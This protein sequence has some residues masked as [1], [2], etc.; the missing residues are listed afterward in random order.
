MGRDCLDEAISA[1]GLSVQRLSRGWR[2]DVGGW[3]DVVVSEEK[4]DTMTLTLNESGLQEVH[5][6]EVVH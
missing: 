5:M 6:S 1:I 4:H 2:C 3:C